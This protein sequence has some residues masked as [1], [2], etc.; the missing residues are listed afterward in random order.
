MRYPADNYG[1]GNGCSHDTATACLFNIDK[2]VWPLKADRIQIGQVIS[3]LVGNAVDAMVKAELLRY[4]RVTGISRICRRKN[5][6]LGLIQNRCL[7][8]PML[9]SV[10]MIRVPE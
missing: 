9:K 6:R 10:F 2:D 7:S 1:F 4:G 5:V 8:V 3:N